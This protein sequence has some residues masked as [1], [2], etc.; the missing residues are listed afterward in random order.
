[1]IGFAAGKLMALDIRTSEAEVIWTAGLRKFTRWGRSGV[2]LV[3]T[4][5]HKG[6]KAA[7]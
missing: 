4:D 6:I 3:V 1:M 2:K 5:A 7:A